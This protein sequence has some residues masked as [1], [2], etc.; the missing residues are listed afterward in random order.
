MAR[1]TLLVA[2][3]LAAAGGGMATECSAA[4][5]NPRSL[6]S[7]GMELFKNAKVAESKAVSHLSG[8]HF[9]T[10]CSRD[11]CF[12]FCLEPPRTSAGQVSPH[13]TKLSSWIRS[14]QAFCGSAV[15]ASTTK[16][17]SQMLPSSLPVCFHPESS[18]LFLDS[19]L[20]LRFNALFN[21]IQMHCS[22]CSTGDVAL[23]PR[24]TEEA[25]WALLSQVVCVSG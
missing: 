14:M 20:G 15:S 22:I 23:N 11:I 19:L 16:T 6:T 7:K 21:E 9:A 12:P 17:A 1:R 8:C 3:V 24:D 10:A 18:R 4:S 13:S 5:E 25:V 2:A